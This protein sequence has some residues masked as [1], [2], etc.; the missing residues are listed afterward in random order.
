[1][2]R[3]GFGIP[4]RQI[5]KVPDTHKIRYRLFSG[6]SPTT[7]VLIPSTYDFKRQLFYL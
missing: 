5:Q 2:A 4:Y 3:L 6:S 7:F 1:M